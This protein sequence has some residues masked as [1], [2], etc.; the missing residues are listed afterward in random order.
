MAPNWSKH[1][2]SS[3]TRLHVWHRGNG[4]N[5]APSPRDRSTLGRPVSRTGDRHSHLCGIVWCRPV[6]FQSSER[7]PVPVL[8]ICL[9]PWRHYCA[10]RPSPLLEYKHTETFLPIKVKKKKKEATNNLPPLLSCLLWLSLLSAV[11]NLIHQANNV[12]HFERKYE[13]LK[14]KPRWIIH[15][16]HDCEV[17]MW[18][19]CEMLSESLWGEVRIPEVAAACDAI[20]GY[21]RTGEQNNGDDM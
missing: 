2:H 14:G 11:C 10:G 17:E 16:V 4:M 1:E 6:L 21:A 20:R 9:L 15:Y 5:E 18:N 7:I 3:R 8:G 13:L 19:K 12:C